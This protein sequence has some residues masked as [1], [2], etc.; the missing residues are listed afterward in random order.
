MCGILVAFISH[1]N[2][3]DV[4]PKARP[5]SVE[6][7][8]SLANASRLYVSAHERFETL[9]IAEIQSNDWRWL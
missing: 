8:V 9:D 7:Y 1:E 4:R 5:F 2:T 6:L 3:C